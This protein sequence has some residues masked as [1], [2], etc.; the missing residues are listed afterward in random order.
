MHGEF[1]ENVTQWITDIPGICGK[2]HKRRW[3]DLPILM[4]F[5]N[6][7]RTKTRRNTERISRY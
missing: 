7:A 5:N 2:M 4:R 1:E 3:F 6:S